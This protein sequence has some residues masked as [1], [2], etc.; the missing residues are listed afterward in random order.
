M[1]NPL[2][3]IFKKLLVDTTEATKEKDTDKLADSQTK[4]QNLQAN[5]DVQLRMLTGEWTRE[6]K[7]LYN[8]PAA[9]RMFYFKNNQLIKRRMTLVGQYKTSVDKILWT[10]AA[11]Q[12]QIEFSKKL[13]DASLDPAL[14]ATLQKEMLLAQQRVNQ[15]LNVMNAL[16]ATMDRQMD[17]MEELEGMSS[18][19]ESDRK[20][21]EL[22]ERYDTCMA[23]GDEKGAQAV[24]AELDALQEASAN[25]VFAG[26]EP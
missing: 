26:I 20:A 24:Q 21:Q 18:T 6:T 16:S 10:I 14:A 5:L 25:A 23:A 13:Q 7:A 4:L 12:D 2:I 22:F 19:G 15:G 1:A 17:A 3:A 11:A 9:Q 8:R